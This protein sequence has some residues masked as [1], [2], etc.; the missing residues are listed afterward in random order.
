MTTLLKFIH[1]GTIAIWSG[2][3]IVLPFLFWQ[4]RGIEVGPELDRLHRLT[5]FVYVGMTSPAAFVAIGTGTALIFLQTTFLE[6]FSMKMVLVG[7]L[8]MLHVVAGLILMHLFEPSGHFGRFSYI[9]LTGSYLVLI[10]AIIWMVLAKPQIDSNQF[11]A[12]LF[13]PGG[14]RHFFGETRMPIP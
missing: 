13:S 2:G 11:A 1:L 14:L 12:D 10:T 3:L 9:A 8:V 4:R 5:R 6:W 7:I